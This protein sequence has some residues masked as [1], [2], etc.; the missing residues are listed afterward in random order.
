QEAFLW[1][2]LN[3]SNVLPFLGVA[4]DTFPSLSVSLV[5][6]FLQQGTVM[7]YLRKYGR[8]N[9]DVVKMLLQVA[10]GLQY[11]H[12]ERV[13]HGDLKG[14]NI[15]VDDEFCIRLADF[16][17]SVFLDATISKSHNAGTVRWMA[18]ELHDPETFGLEHALRT[19]ASDMY[20]FSHV[21]MEIFTGREPF[22][23][24]R[25]ATVI[26]KVMNGHRPERPS[27]TDSSIVAEMPDWLWDLITLC[28]KHK[29]EERPTS[30]AVLDTIE[31]RYHSHGMSRPKSS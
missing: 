5:S 15:L 26:Y 1:K 18:P 6:P 25:E 22:P 16:G 14:T 20:A 10:Q 8:Q 2:N 29:P 7:D 3:H 23:D 21:C 31:G 27:S 13:V 24:L 11:L 12:S 19:P 9:V 4:F 17:L 30:T 28:W